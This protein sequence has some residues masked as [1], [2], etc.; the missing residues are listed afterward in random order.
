MTPDPTWTPTEHGYAEYIDAN[1]NDFW[2]FGGDTAQCAEAI[3]KLVHSIEDLKGVARAKIE[4]DYA[5]G[6]VVKEF[7]DFHQNELGIE[8]SQAQLWEL[9]IPMNRYT[10][11]P[12]EGCDD[13]HFLIM[14]FRFHEKTDYVLGVYFDAKG[15]LSYFAMES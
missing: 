15:E 2:L 6:T 4:S 10:F 1:G 7:I 11:H 8:P 14:D 5:T 3:N 12:A 9:I 13:P